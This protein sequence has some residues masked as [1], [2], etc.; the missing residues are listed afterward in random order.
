MADHTVID[1]AYKKKD[2]VIQMKTKSM[3]SIEGEKIRVDS[4]LLFKRLI[5]VYSLDE[6]SAAMGY[7]LSSQ[8]MSFF[9]KDRR[10]RQTTTEGS[11]EEFGRKMQL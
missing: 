4:A 2:M 6:L 8:P 1:F 11:F 3:I 9:E 10:D 5:A 7:E